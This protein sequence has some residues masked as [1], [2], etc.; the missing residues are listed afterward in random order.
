MV[1]SWA[2]YLVVDMVPLSHLTELRLSTK[3][4]K[5]QFNTMHKIFDCLISSG[6]FEIQNQNKRF[7]KKF[8]LDLFLS[9][10]DIDIDD[11]GADVSCV[12]KKN[13][14]EIPVNKRPANQLMDKDYCFKRAGG[15][16]SRH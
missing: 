8:Y 9:R 12:D 15:P 7:P 13:F 6:V 11:T 16:R 2:T 4:V 10:H 5:S 3:P 14:L 1:V